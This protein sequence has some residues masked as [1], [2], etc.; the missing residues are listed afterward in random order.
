MSDYFSKSSAFFQEGG[1]GVK[2]ELDL[3]DQTRKADLKIVTVVHKFKF[4]KNVDLA[5]LKSKGYKLDV[6]KLEIT[7]GDL[8]NIR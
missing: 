3:S 4:A 7:S 1:R 2:L 5:S 8:K 6:V